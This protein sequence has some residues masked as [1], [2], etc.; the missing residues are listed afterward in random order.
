MTRRADEALEAV[1]RSARG[2]LLV[3]SCLIACLLFPGEAAAQDLGHKF[4]GG[5]GVDAGVQGP[6][7][8]Y[9]A[10]RL[11]WY[12]ANR[13][14]SRTGATLP[15]A[16]FDL[17]ALGNGLGLHGTVQLSQELHLGAT[18]AVPLA[19][20][21][22]SSDD[23]RTSIDRFG[24]GDVYVMPLRLG[25]RLPQFDVVASYGM[26]I[27]TGR[28]E[29]EGG[30]GVGRGF[31]THQFSLGGAIFFDRQRRG[32]AS[33]L[34][35]YD[36]NLRKQGLDLTRGDT[37][38]TQ[39]GVGVLLFGMLDVGLAGYALWQVRDDRGSDLPDVLRG[40]RDRVFGVGP[41]VNLLLPEL[42]TRFGA[43]YTWDV[44]ARSR[45]E[46]GLLVVNVAVALWRPAPARTGP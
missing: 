31:W 35:N 21:A 32:R 25:W 11:L 30:G 45:P 6:P 26:Y 42:R 22:S 14:V 36:L 28:F 12:S 5:V 10:D 41:E 9:L 7:G 24:L 40:A 18:V 8:L 38:Q 37:V 27:P 34:S 2:A 20:L 46:G 17:D 39:G 23:P 15:L 33:L 44:G 29:P 1:S 16:G 3:G 19:H 4:P 43:R 13:V